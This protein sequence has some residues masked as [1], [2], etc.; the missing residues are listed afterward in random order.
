MV[1]DLM[2]KGSYHLVVDD[3]VET[4][5]VVADLINPSHANNRKN[6]ILVLL[7][8]FTQGVNGTTIYAEKL[9][10]IYFTENNKFC[11]NLHYNGANS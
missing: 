7:K 6:D 9:Y 11:L 4:D 2:E 10:K 5:L 3:L 8:E 1:L